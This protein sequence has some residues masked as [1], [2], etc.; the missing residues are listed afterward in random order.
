MP[1]RIAH[2]IK[3]PESLAFQRLDQA[4]AALFP[5][6][7]RSRLQAWIKSGEL[8][9]DGA[10]RRQKDKL[11][12]GELV[13]I[14]AEAEEFGH[15][16]EE[17]DLDVVHE[18]EAVII[19]NKPPGLVVHPGAGN[20]RGTL[21]NALLYRYPELDELPR[22]GIVH[23]LDKDTSG[24][25]VVAR[26]L[27]SQTELVR[28]LQARDVK[29]IYEAVVYGVVERDAEVDAPIDRHPVK[30]VRMSIR[31]NGREAVT[32]Y[33]VLERFSRHSHLELSL[34]TG[35]TH[36]IRVHMQHIRHPIVGD[37]TYGGTYRQPGHGS[38]ERLMDALRQFPR[39]ALHA[40]RLALRHPATGETASW[41][42]PLEQDIEDLLTVLREESPDA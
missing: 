39:Q 15:V 6:Y 22:A 14:D 33:H 4:A 16:S 3:V 26:T 42:V 29:R 11:L 38:S 41:E 7:S 37:P 27:E 31:E 21:L 40:R 25:M 8:Q 23:R 13:T 18:D 28:Q 10:R 36:Q 2:Q 34:Q 32:R 24:I 20:P 35:R 30:R 12:G 17:M 1:S 5:Q 9:V 19:I